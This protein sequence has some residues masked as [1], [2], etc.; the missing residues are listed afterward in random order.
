[1]ARGVLASIEWLALG[2]PIYVW[3]DELSRLSGSFRI[4]FT[5]T[6]G[7]PPPPAD[8]RASEWT[9]FN[10]HR[11]PR[12]RA[13]RNWC[14]VFVPGML[15]EVYEQGFHVAA[16]NP[17][18]AR[19]STYQRVEQQTKTWLVF[20][21]AYL[22]S[23]AGEPSELPVVLDGLPI[24]KPW[25]REGS[26]NMSFRADREAV[27]FWGMQDRLERD[28]YAI[29]P[30]EKPP[31][32]ILDP[33]HHGF[34]FRL[35]LLS[36]L[37]QLIFDN[38]YAIPSEQAFNII[39]DV[40]KALWT[41][42]YRPPEEVKRP[43][44]EEVKRPLLEP[45]QGPE[46]EALRAEWSAGAHGLFEAI[47]ASLGA[48]LSKLP[49]FR[50][51]P[52]TAAFSEHY[53][54]AELVN[55]MIF[56]FLADEL[57]PLGLSAALLNRY[58]SNVGAYS[59]RAGVETVWPQR[60]EGPGN[61]AG[62]TYLKGTPLHPL[63]DI[64]VPY[65]PFTD[66][67]RFTHHWCMGDNGSGKTTFLRHLIRHD[68]ER[69]AKGECSLVAIDSKKLIRE[70][71]TLKQ[72]APGGPLDGRLILMDADS[73]FPLNPFRIRKPDGR[74]DTKRG[75]AILTYM[76][77]G[78]SD[79]S[80]LQVGVLRHY[81]RAA[82]AQDNP[83]LYTVLDLMLLPKDGQPPNA[84]RMD[85]ETVKWFKHT[86]KGVASLTS[87]GAEQRLIDFLDEF[88]DSPLV[89]MLC[90]D[91]FALDMDELDRGGKVLLVDTN[92]NAYGKDGATLLGRLIVALID[93]LATRRTDHP[94]P[95]LFCLMDEAQDYIAQDPIFADILEKARSSKIGMTIAHHHTK[96]AGGFLPGVVAALEQTGIHSRC[97][98][99][100]TAHIRTRS[101]EF[102]LPV[103]ELEFDREPQ[104]D[105]PQYEALRERLAEKYPYKASPPPKEPSGG[106]KG[107]SRD[108]FDRP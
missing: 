14:R 10:P 80:R 28:G 26:L 15:A 24:E 2:C 8:G 94:G 71:R 83:T 79:A 37:R 4:G 63:F 85:G 52:F 82:Y 25:K 104:M 22:W 67:M 1:M 89:A 86:R 93:Q 3:K 70:M 7:E 12:R 45:E 42:S 9:R 31:A 74:P 59:D 51:A 88:R 95:P 38:D 44:P 23:D 47:V 19:Y 78:L 81:I 72:F 91:S 34:D 66:E 57:K 106:K 18:L 84:D 40:G 17:V 75:T 33:S 90:A 53:G 46:L 55:Q 96:Q 11:F 36:R 27:D 105:R 107:G 97:R 62:D 65:A 69:A 21:T 32:E 29:E 58:Y 39:L 103:K 60:Y 43:R 50:S 49:R 16:V 54:S 13:A 99:P 87:G 68:M 30:M 20:R 100:G 98:V 108:S 61:L 92:R 77:A 101:G 76:L 73:I 64:E 56:P 5:D 41:V 48:Y 102:D 35:V 6:R